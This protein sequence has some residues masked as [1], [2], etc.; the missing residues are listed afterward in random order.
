MPSSKPPP[1]TLNQEP[2][3]NVLILAGDIDGNLGDRAILCATCEELRR[4]VPDIQI[5]I[6]SSNPEADASF[7][8]AQTIEAGPR[9]AWSL[10]RAARKSDL[11]LCGGGGL[12]QDDTSLLKMPYWALRLAFVRTFAR[13]IVGFSLGIGP[14]QKA[15]SRIAARLAFACMQMVSARDPLAK[16]VAAQLTSKPVS[17]VPDPALMLTPSSPREADEALQS[18]GIPVH[19]SP[20]VGVS[21][22]RSFHQFPSLI[23]HKYAAK[24]RLRRIPGHEP[25]HQMIALLAKVLDEVSRRHQATILFLPT[26]NVSHEAD[27][28]VSQAIIDQMEST[29]TAILRIQ[30]PR[31]YKAVTGRLSAM[32][33]GRMHPAILSAA[34]GTPVVGLSYNQKFRGFF[35]LLACEHRLITIEDFVRDELASGLLNLL[36]KSISEERAVSPKVLQLVEQTRRFTA[37]ILC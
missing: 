17:I 16:R 34:M 32:L 2:V 25:F 12:F 6:I 27:D 1:T 26:Y 3:R 14:L 33:G 21:V 31:L 23:P 15:S 20:I 29:K 28:L 8:S 19:D 4:L 35:R 24:Y 5:T 11:V 9:G 18:V 30:D 36:S 10:A 37:E 7:F 13:R 22:R